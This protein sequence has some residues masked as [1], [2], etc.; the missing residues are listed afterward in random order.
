MKQ[1]LSVFLRFVRSN[2]YKLLLF[3][4]LLAM[5]QVGLVA[6]EAKQGAQLFHDAVDGSWA[7]RLWQVGYLATLILL[8]VTGGE[9]GSRQGYTLKRLGISYQMVYL[10]QAVYNCVMFFL[11][12]AVMAGA[13][14]VAAWVFYRMVPTRAENHNLFLSFYLGQYLHNLMPVTNAVRWIRNVVITLALG[15]TGAHFPL[16][17]R[18]K[19][20]SFSAIV[21]GVC[22]MFG[23]SYGF[24]GS[25]G[26]TYD[27][28]I[29]FVALLALLTALCDGLWK[30]SDKD[31]G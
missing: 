3:Y 8:W 20:F 12:W 25:D 10:W 21:A 18:R 2:F 16:Q 5:A 6:W 30:E 19:R 29:T 4:A 14:F 23:M 7:F 22:G 17:Q 13:M 24:T 9:F 1:H 28:V 27:C 15:F 11:F 26:S 31:E